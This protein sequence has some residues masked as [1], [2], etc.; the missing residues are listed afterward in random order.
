MD[1]ETLKFEVRSGNRIDVYYVEARA[2]GGLQTQIKNMLS[3][4]ELKFCGPQG[5][6]TCLEDLDKAISQ[7]H[8]IM[9]RITEAGGLIKTELPNCKVDT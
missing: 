5:L 2:L 3:K 8:N 9:N 1:S 4:P 6:V 7:F